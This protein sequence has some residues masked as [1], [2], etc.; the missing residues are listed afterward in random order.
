AGTHQAPPLFGEADA[1]EPRNVVNAA[2]RRGGRG[3]RLYAYAVRVSSERRTNERVA[4]A[5]HSVAG[6]RQPDRSTDVG[7]DADLPE[8]ESAGKGAGGR[9]KV[10]RSRSRSSSHLLWAR[11]SGRE[12]RPAG[13]LT[14][15]QI[16]AAALRIV[17]EEGVAA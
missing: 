5:R 7:V 13:G 16:V 4:Q 3:A 6:T 10:H 1:V 17:D 8:S 14:D 11:E 9:L 15:D 2:L 12:N